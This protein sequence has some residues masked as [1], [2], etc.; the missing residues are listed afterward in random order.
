MKAASTPRDNS[1]VVCQ[2]TSRR[3]GVSARNA[4]AMSHL[5][6]ALIDHLLEGGQ[7]FGA[8]VL[9][10]E[11]VLKQEQRIAVEDAVHKLAQ[12]VLPLLLAAAGGLVNVSASFLA[13][14]QPAGF[15]QLLHGRQD[16]RVRQRLVPAEP[17][18]HLLH[19]RLA[20]LPDRVHD[21]LLERAEVVHGF[22]GHA[23]GLPN[24][25]RNIPL[26]AVRRLI[27]LRTGVVSSAFSEKKREASPPRQ[28]GSS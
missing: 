17:V 21:G 19:R 28:Q 27:V 1:S 9:V 24:R 18:E 11:E 20:L 4:L 25:E 5:L 16:R 3:N 22:A 12:G 10:F 2:R 8:Q 7:V 26:I 23:S 13:V 15:L 14:L 6:P